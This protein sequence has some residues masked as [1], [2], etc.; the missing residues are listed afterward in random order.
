MRLGVR[1]VNFD[2]PGGPAAIG[3]ILARAGAAAEAAGVN[4]HV[5]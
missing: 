2:V 1:L 4:C 3:P 5:G